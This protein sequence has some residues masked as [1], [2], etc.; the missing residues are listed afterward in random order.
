MEA[1]SGFAEVYDLFMDNVPYEEW[2]AR[3]A[4]LLK[5]N[6][7]S[8]GLVLD[9]CCGTGK[10]TRLLRDKGYDMIGVDS[11]YEMLE[12]AREAEYG[13]D[14]V[15]E[16]IETSENASS[17]LYL[18]QDAREFELYGTVGAIV[19][20]CDSLNYIV[21]P[22]ELREVFR[23]A[24]NYLEA[25]GLFIFD[26]NTPYKYQKLLADHTFAENRED[27]AFIWDNYYDEE[28]GINEYELTLFIEESDGRFERYEETHLER[29]YTLDEVKTLLA[30]AGMEFV[31]AYDEYTKEPLRDD[32]ERMLIV[33]KEKK[34]EGKYY[35]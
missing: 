25:E 15:D 1:Y 6:H 30:E 31:D 8:E 3:I 7:M 23:L 29:C 28:T 16:Y 20:A 34:V 19:S 32:S 14:A 11:S 22:K 27:C 4:E 10:L 33:A 21:E 5:E 13:D 2:A 17:I 12:I 24:N 9:L 26:L 35:E 18:N